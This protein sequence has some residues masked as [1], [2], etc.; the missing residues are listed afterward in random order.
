MT[1]PGF[2]T[3]N[4]IRTPPNK[5][6]SILA[7][8]QYQVD[9]IGKCRLWFTRCSKRTL[10]QRFGPPTRTNDRKNIP[11][12]NVGY[13]LNKWV[14]SLT[15]PR[16]SWQP[17]PQTWPCHLIA[18]SFPVHYSGKTGSK[19]LLHLIPQSSQRVDQQFYQRYLK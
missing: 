2:E 9:K 7:K 19:S 4:F 5:H 6:A 16:W 10:R 18:G 12:I 14:F 15:W 11:G 1:L 8:Y 3:L 17:Q 13:K